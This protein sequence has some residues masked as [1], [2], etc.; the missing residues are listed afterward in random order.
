MMYSRLAM[1]A[2]LTGLLVAAQP[3]SS[4]QIGRDGYDFPARNPSLAAQFTF[5]QRVANRNAAGANA[6]GL[7][8]LNQFVTTYSSTST[9]VGNMN[10][11][12][13][14]LSE[15]SSGSVGLSTD[16]ESNG[17]Q[18]SEAVADIAIDHSI[19]NTGNMTITPQDYAL[20]PEPEE[21]PA[22]E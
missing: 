9:S 14:I 5:Q 12:T 6:A 4:Q 22:A 8:A 18:G 21:A 13:Q 17:N 20:V 15:G 10:T 1:F 3:A 11:I 16:Q 2:A 7:G 19:K